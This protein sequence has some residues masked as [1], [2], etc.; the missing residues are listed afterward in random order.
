MEYL[1]SLQGFLVDNL[2]LDKA[3]IF[4]FAEVGE[5]IVH[6]GDA[7]YAFGANYTAN[8][9]INDCELPIS[10]VLYQV[11]RFMK[12]QQRFMCGAAD[13]PKFEFELLSRE[14]RNIYIE[15]PIQETVTVQVD[16]NGTNLNAMD[17]P[18]P[19]TDGPSLVTAQAQHS[20]GGIDAG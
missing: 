7:N 3:K 6:P 13:R 1:E 18:A 8:I 4:A 20:P 10:W 11:A 5:L 15:V 2:K 14:R 17:T 12:S 19:V 9:V 16:S